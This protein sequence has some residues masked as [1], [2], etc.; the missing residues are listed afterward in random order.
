MNI[1]R[2][3]QLQLTLTP[4]VTLCERTSPVHRSYLL[5]DICRE[6]SQKLNYPRKTRWLAFNEEVLALCKHA[7]LR[8]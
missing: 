4:V 6:F 8:H 1:R 2:Y 7:A 5:L 3:T